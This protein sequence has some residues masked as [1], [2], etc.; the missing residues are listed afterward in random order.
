MDPCGEDLDGHLFGR[1]HRFEVSVTSTVRD[2][3][4]ARRDDIEVADHAALVQL[5]PLGDDL[6]PVVV[7]MTFVLRRR[8]RRHAVE[9][10]EPGRRA[11]LEH[12]YLSATCIKPA[13]P[14][15]SAA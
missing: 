4:Q 10:D 13:S 14:R 15:S 3:G 6:D 8:L 11:D 2:V 12:Q 5:V 1:A 9:R 7:W